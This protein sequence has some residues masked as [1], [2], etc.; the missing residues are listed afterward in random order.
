VSLLTARGGLQAFLTLL[1]LVMV[2]AG[3][4][5]VLFGAASVPREGV[6]TPDVDTE[7]RFFAVWYVVVGAV[8][9]GATRRL[10]GAGPIVKM[11]GV[12]FFLAGCA[13]VLSWVAVG[14]P[15][16]TAIALMVIELVLPFVIIPWHAKAAD[17]MGRANG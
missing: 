16:A 12:G 10:E 2:V 3:A 5:A 4:V 17:P 6:V 7:M 9:L 13:R 1:G 15:H 14:K 8:L 11:V